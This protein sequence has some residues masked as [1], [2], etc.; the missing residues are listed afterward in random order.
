MNRSQRSAVSQFPIHE[1]RAVS[2]DT[3]IWTKTAD[4]VLTKAIKQQA[5]SGTVH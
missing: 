4:A 3:I 1:R 5:T 2:P